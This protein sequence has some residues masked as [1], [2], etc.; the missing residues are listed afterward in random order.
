[1]SQLEFNYNIRSGWRERV[2]SP[3]VIGEKF[4]KTLDALSRVGSLRY[5]RPGASGG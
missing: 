4:I 5:R 3:A 2:E 1:M